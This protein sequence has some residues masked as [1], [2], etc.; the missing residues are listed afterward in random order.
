MSKSDSLLD[1]IKHEKTDSIKVYYLDDLA[2]EVLNTNPDSAIIISKQGLTLSL[3]IKWKTGQSVS[4]ASIGTFY[5]LKGDYSP[6]LDYYLKALK[7]NES[8]NNKSGIAHNL[9]NIGNLF[10]TQSEFEKALGYYERALKIEQELLKGSLTEE[11]ARY[12]KNRISMWQGNIGN[13]YNGQ[14][15]KV[16]DTQLKEG[17]FTKALDYYSMALKTDEELNDKNGMSNWYANIGVVYDYKARALTNVSDKNTLFSKA[18]EYYQKSLRLEEE[19]GNTNGIAQRLMNI[20]TLYI[21]TNNYGNAEKELKKAMALFKEIGA[22]DDER[23]A[24]QSLTELYEKTGRHKEA[25]QHLK[26]AVALKDSIFNEEKNIEMA[27]R[28][29]SFEFEKKEAI[30][31]TEHKKELENERAVAEEKSRKQ[32]VIIYSAVAGLMLVLLFT[33]FIFRTLRITQRQKSIIETQ[34]KEVEMAKVEIEDQKK[35]VEEKNRDITDSINYAQR[36]QRAMLAPEELLATHL[37]SYFLFFKPKDIVSGDFYWARDLGNGRF[38]LVTADSTGHGVPGA[39]MSVLNMACL[40]E[41]TAKANLQ[42][43]LVLHETRK[44]IIE[45]L[46]NDGSKEGGKDGMD[47]SL[48]VFDFKNMMLHAACANNPVWLVRN[49]E[50]MEL[51]PDK[52]PVGK[53]DKQQE[54]FTLHTF[55]FQKND[56]VYTLTDGFADQFGGPKGK[57]FMYKPMKELLLSIY[58]K[59]MEQ[60]KETLHETFESWKAETEQVDDVTVIGVRI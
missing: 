49:G 59:S 50:L 58:D 48:V 60:Q 54:P 40:K 39:I 6:A 46:K 41:V 13:V 25:L 53:H 51:K 33:V 20:G 42:P 5:F 1:K 44:L 27:R 21:Q 36:I 7:I 56:M 47:C 45:N 3:K 19:I 14:A 2:W 29:M 52:M 15:A 17:L 38:A 11:K 35:I 4:L 12:R 23:L 31:K 34:K 18:M 43:H 24:E 16:K 22:R 10:Y 32:K 26:R 55:N 28:E 9:G 30:A 57:K 8:L 37:P